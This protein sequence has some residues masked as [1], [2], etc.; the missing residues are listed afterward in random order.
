[1]AKK[2]LFISV[3]KIP[4]KE[5]LQLVTLIADGNTISQIA[6]FAGYSRR[7]LEGKIERIKLEVNAKNSANLVAIFLRNKLIK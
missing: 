4:S 2:D 3:T 6:E 1:M 5:T 7:T